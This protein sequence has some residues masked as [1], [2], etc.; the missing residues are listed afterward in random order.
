MVR[1]SQCSLSIQAR[2]DQCSASS[3]TLEVV[4][5]SMPSEFFP[6]TLPRHIQPE[7]PSSFDKD[8]CCFED[9]LLRLEELC[10]IQKWRELFSD[11]LMYLFALSLHTEVPKNPKHQKVC[12]DSKERFSQWT[13]STFTSSIRIVTFNWRQPQLY[14]LPFSQ[15]IPH[16]GGKD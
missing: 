1:P 7:L 15:R 3:M 14:S 2:L 11:G 6:R 5:T 10:R 13:M 16:L 4:E 12:F 9:R 8:C